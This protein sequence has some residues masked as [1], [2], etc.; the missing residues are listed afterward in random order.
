MLIHKYSVELGNKEIGDVRC[1]E[2]R[3]SV[4]NGNLI[5]FSFPLI[6]LHTSDETQIFD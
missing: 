4:R 1:A 3:G 6:L 5:S 2:K